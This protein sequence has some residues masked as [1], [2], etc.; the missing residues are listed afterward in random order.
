M[1]RALNYLQWALVVIGV[2]F[3]AKWIVHD[4]QPSQDTGSTVT[5]APAK[6]VRDTPKIAVPMNAP[7]KVYQGGATIK[8]KLNL[9][10]DVAQDDHQQIIASSK[11]EGD[12]PHTVTTVINTDTGESQT[13]VRTDPLPWLAWDDH[14]G[15]GLYAGYK[16][17]A[18]ATRLQAHQELF[19]IKGVR[20]GVLASMDLPITGRPDTFIGFGAEYRW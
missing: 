10:P 4:R 17:G 8:K 18:P 9:P 7:V 1:I 13:Y 11:I 16:N 14:G 20:V 15:V 2:I 12:Q 6:E 3:I 19:R 5:A